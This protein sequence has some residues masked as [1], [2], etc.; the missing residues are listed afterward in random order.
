CAGAHAGWHPEPLPRAALDR[1]SSRRGRGYRAGSLALP[2]FERRHGF[3]DIPDNLHLAGHVSKEV[4]RLLLGGNEL[5]DWLAVLGDE[6]GLS[7][8]KDLVHHSQT[9]CLKFTCGHFFHMVIVV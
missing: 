4:V 2:V 1:S 3:H 8:P 9:L 6:H 5:G 7:T